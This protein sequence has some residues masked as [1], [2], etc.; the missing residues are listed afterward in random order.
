M[1]HQLA[2]ALAGLTTGI[3]V[4]TV[5]A[6]ERQHGM[7]SSWVTQV[8]G[9][10][11]LIMAAMDQEHVTHQMV[12]QSGAFAL[13]IVGTQSKHLEDYFYSA[14]SRQPDNLAP[15]VL[16]IGHT[17]T[18]L[19][20]DA[21]ASLDCRL[22]S[23]Q[24]AGDHTL[25]IGEVV[26]VYVRNTDRPLTSQELPYVYLGGESAV[27][28]DESEATG[29][30]VRGSD[31]GGSWSEHND[32][33]PGETHAGTKQVPMVRTLVFNGPLPKHGHGNIDTAISGIDPA[34]AAARVQRQEPG[35][36]SQADRTRH[37]PPPGA[38]GFEPEIHGITTENFRA[39]RHDK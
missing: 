7:S 15:F 32:G 35:K 21:L 28:S 11:V 39:R 5:R 6:G 29:A 12:L 31:S 13:N 34:G 1:E 30:G 27:R 20:R 3:Y 17:G 24:V 8:S 16:E 19:L 2:T 33:H 14:Q 25:C 18:P 26:E 10:P 37:Q 38:G 23:T 4:L 36:E 9:A 22:V